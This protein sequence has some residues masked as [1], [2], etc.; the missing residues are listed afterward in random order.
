MTEKVKLRSLI[1]GGAFTLLFVVLVTRLYWVQVVQGAEL[2]SDAKMMWATDKE[3]R[4]VRGAILDRNDKVLAEDS[5]AYTLALNPKI[6]HDKGIENEVVQGI[7]EILNISNDSGALST[8]ADKIRTR[9]NQKRDDGSYYTQVEI[10]NE[11]WKIDAE[12][13]DKIKAL[14]KELQLKLNTKKSLGILLLP[15]SKRFYPSGGLAAHLLGY[16]DKEGKPIMGLETQLDSYLKGESGWLSY[17]KDRYGVELPHSQSKYQPAVNG[18]NVRLT[19]DKNIQFYIE[20]AMQKVVDRW[21]PKSLTAIAVDPNTMEIL[22]LANMPSFNP[23]KYWEAKRQ[24]DFINHAVASQYE[25]GSTFKLVTLAAAVEEGI[26]NPNEKYQSGSIAVPGRRLHDHNISGWGQI[27]YLEGLKRS[28]N[29]AFVKMGYENL[30]Q[31]KLRSYIDK[32]GFGEKTGVDIAGEVGGIVN[33]RYPAEFATATY[34]QGLTVTAMQQTAAYAAIAN[35]GKLMWPHL[36]K[37]IYNPET[38]ESVKKFEPKE[39]RRVVSESTAKQVG[40]YLEQVVADQSLGTGRKAYIEGYRIAGKTGTANKV[41]QGEKGYA[42]GKWVISF[43]GYAPLENPQILV[44]IIVDEPDLG[45]NYHLGGDVAA[46]AFKEIVSQTLRYMGTAPNTA[47]Q[48]RVQAA[49]REMLTAVPDLTDLPLDQARRTMDK[50]GVTVEPIGQGDKVIAQSLV[51]G[52]EIG[53]SQ[54]IFILMQEGGD[55]PVP[56]MTG[57]SLRDAVGLCSFINLRCLAEG[58]GYVANQN[59][60]GAG[61]DRVLHLQLRPYGEKAESTEPKKSEAEESSDSEEDK[62]KE[63]SP[64]SVPNGN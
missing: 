35:G 20:S 12:V 30:G 52:T 46:P 41:V 13:A 26:F 32:F 60:E 45:G 22:G 49:E 3:L 2:L 18:D 44:T 15:E 4:P 21:R 48:Q 58:E 10:R 62:E 19:L 43:A 16:T 8:L 6:I 37:E 39:I 47:D 54:R 33:M 9:I 40:E 25:P 14:E 53:T 42:E 28:S 5:P 50:F 31:N 38:G 55:V 57:K 61:E 24:S 17:E 34:G 63:E 1:I 23:N 64:V 11:G 36:I 56:V 29:V 7:S 27:S 51:A 59:L